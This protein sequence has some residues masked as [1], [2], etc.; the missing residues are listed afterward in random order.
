MY[1]ESGIHYSLRNIISNQ[2]IGAKQVLGHCAG[3]RSEK[4]K[5]GFVE[6]DSQ[7]VEN[8]SQ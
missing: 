1:F 7:I 4:V 6:N 8:D 5:A 2:T 3:F